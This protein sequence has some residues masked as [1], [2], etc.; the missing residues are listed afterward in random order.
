MH[1]LFGAWGE[2]VD[3]AFDEWIARLPRASGVQGARRCDRGSVGVAAERLHVA[4]PVIL[5]LVVGGEAA[6]VRVDVRVAPST[7]HLV[8]DGLA[9]AAQSATTSD[10]LRADPH[11]LPKGARLLCCCGSLHARE[12]ARVKADI[13]VSTCTISVVNFGAACACKNAHIFLLSFWYF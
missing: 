10:M 2:I 5:K 11:R 4:I 9:R 6:V 12:P 13:R 1:A 3:L 8:V 7:V